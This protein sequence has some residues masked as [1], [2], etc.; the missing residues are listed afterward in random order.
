MLGNILVSSLLLV[1]VISQNSAD[2]NTSV[3]VDTDSST[4]VSV[5]NSVNTQ[6]QVESN[7]RV[8][9]Q[10]E[11]EDF[12]QKVAQIRDQN[13]QRLVTN[14]D[15][16]IQTVNKKWTDHW[17][18]ALDRLDTILGKIETRLQNYGGDTSEI[19][20]A[21][22]DAKDAI[23]TARDAVDTQAQKDYVLQI[24][25]ESTLGSGMR[26]LISQFHDDLKTTRETVSTAWQAVHDVFVAVMR[27]TNQGNTNES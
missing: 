26:T 20:S 13:R 14:I 21:I 6:D 23:A 22:T 5:Q 11:R 12:K 1:S 17:S 15:E 16:R 2:V 7:V 9:L 10:Q 24:T 19:D 3:N 18:T 4:S 27:V 8:R 25:D